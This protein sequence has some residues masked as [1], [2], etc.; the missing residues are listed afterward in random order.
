MP[1][2][3]PSVVRFGVFEVSLKARELRK[4]G[5]RIRLQ[6][7][8]FQILE[9]LLARPGEIVTRDAIREKLWDEDT[10]VEFDH[11]LNT[12]VQ[13]LRAALGDS[14][15]S[16]R[17]LETVP[18]IGYRFVAPVE[19]RAAAETSESRCRSAFGR[20]APPV[21]ET[22]PARQTCVASFR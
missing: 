13:K 16:P 6:E 17:F 3:D 19:A 9:M 12:A 10:F 18:R 21:Q 1:G 14:A 4:H 5:I 2:E 11:S 7:Q 15:D 20:H 22:F 8:P